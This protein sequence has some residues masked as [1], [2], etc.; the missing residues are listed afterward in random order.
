MLYSLNPI[1]DIRWREL[2]DASGNSSVFHMPEWLEALHQ[3]YGYEPVVFA[4][5]GGE[6]LRNGVPFCKIKSWLTGSRLVSLPFSDHCQPLGAEAD[7]RAVLKFLAVERQVHKWKYIECR[8]LT[9]EGFHGMGETAFKMGSKFCFHQIDLSARLEQIFK[10]FHKDCIQRKIRKAERE[11]LRYEKGRGPEILGDFYAL[12]LKTRQ[13]HGLPPQPRAWFKNLAGCMGD[14]LTI[15]TAKKGRVPV[16]SILTLSFRKSVTYKYGCS[17]TEF[18][19]L[20]GTPFLFWQLIQEAKAEGKR[21]L[22]LGRSDLDNP[23]LIRF[24]D[25]LGASRSGLTYYR[26]SSQTVKQK[27]D[28]KEKVGTQ[29]FRRMPAPCLAVAGK[30]FYKHIG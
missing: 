19:N 22:D 14:S 30:L 18:N 21:T 8:P 16:A 17:D 9:G 11:G 29:V 23:G 12:M 15:R 2:V 24:K 20:G 3:T 5:E 1:V 10:N 25:H 26:N 7:I 13:R 4:N 27:S 6:R 28:W